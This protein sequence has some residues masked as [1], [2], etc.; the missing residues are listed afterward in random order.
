L[1]GKDSYFGKYT[2]SNKRDTIYKKLKCSAYDLVF[3]ENKKEGI[4]ITFKN[5]KMYY[6][7]DFGN[8]KNIYYVTSL[9]TSNLKINTDLFEVPK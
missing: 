3:N 9:D 7:C 1:N 2:T 5:I 4:L 6:S 8:V